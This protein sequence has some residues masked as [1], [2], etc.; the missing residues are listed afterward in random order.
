[1]IRYDTVHTTL[2]GIGWRQDGLAFLLIYILLTV[3]SL[4]Y[5]IFLFLNLSGKNS[6]LLQSLILAGALLIGIGA[7]FPVRETSPA[8][9]YFLHS[10]LC[11]I[12]GVLSIA[13]VTYMIILYCKENKEKVKNVTI[14]FGELFI[15]VVVTFCLLETAALFEV[16][17]SFLFLVAMFVIN[18]ILLYE[19][20][21][22][23]NQKHVNDLKHLEKANKKGAT[24]FASIFGSMAALIFIG[25]VSLVMSNPIAAVAEFIGGIV[26]GVVGLSLCAVN[27]PIYR[28]L[29][30]KNNESSLYRP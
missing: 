8:Y 13:A 5:Q 30:R 21:R 15:I 25:G 22:G 9:S 3:P 20:E 11:Q 14:L 23:K 27:I 17:S 4:I 24:I 26:L 28:K 18:G 29:V 7:L 16:G 2:S 10:I 12:G 1:M 19:R 6:K